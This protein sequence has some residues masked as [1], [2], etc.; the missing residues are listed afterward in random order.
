M[1]HRYPYIEQFI[2]KDVTVV[3]MDRK[4]VFGRLE[5]NYNGRCPYKVISADGDWL[6]YKSHIR[7]I[8]ERRSS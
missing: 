7:K 8:I 2:G 4:E 3:F 1:N 6:F 5:H